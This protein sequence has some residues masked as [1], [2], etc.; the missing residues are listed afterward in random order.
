VKAAEETLSAATRELNVAG[1]IKELEGTFH[2]IL[3]ASAEI[4]GHMVEITQQGLT[5]DQVS[6]ELGIVFN[7][8][9]IYL[10]QTFPPSDQAPGHEERLKMTTTVLDSAEQ[11]LLE[12]GGK[13]GMSEDGLERV[14]RTFA[15]LKPQIEKLVVITGAPLLEV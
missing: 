2:N 15:S 11:G 12:L 1:K 3:A 10:G 5:L 13:H 6:D 4:R 8:T 7:D 9:L 14:R